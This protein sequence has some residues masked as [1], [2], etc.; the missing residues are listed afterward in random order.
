[1]RSSPDITLAKGRVTDHETHRPGIFQNCLCAS[2]GY[3]K[4]G[5]GA[6]VSLASD[7]ARDR[8]SSRNWK[9]AGYIA[10]VF[11]ACVTYLGWWCQSYL[12][13]TFIERVKHLIPP[14]DRQ[15][16]TGGFDIGG[17]EV[18][19]HG[20]IDDGLIEHHHIDLP[21]YEQGPV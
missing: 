20:Q 4:F 16:D 5:S 2:T 9:V 6:T 13:E 19:P 21:K 12:R 14:A 7:T 1:M 17:D 15:D 11:L 3:W 18:E 8:A 10:L